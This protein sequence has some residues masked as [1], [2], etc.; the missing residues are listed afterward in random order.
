MVIN[1]DYG[2]HNVVAPE[3]EYPLFVNAVRAD[4]RLRTSTTREIMLPLMSNRAPEL[5]ATIGL[6]LPPE[7]ASEDFQPSSESKQTCVTD[8]AIEF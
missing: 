3:A 6:L 8:S 2:P 5:V 7:V 4:E 1:T